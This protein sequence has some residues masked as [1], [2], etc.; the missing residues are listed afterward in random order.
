MGNSFSMPASTTYVRLFL[1]QLLVVIHSLHRLFTK[2]VICKKTSPPL[3]IAVAAQDA[4]GASDVVFP[5]AESDFSLEPMFGESLA[6]I[7]IPARLLETRANETSG[8]GMCPHCTA[9]WCV[10]Y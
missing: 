6:H 2:C 7:K 1:S 5:V 9:N 10:S 3:D 4:F 8:S